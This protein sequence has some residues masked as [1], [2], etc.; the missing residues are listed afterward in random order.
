ME[1]PGKSTYIALKHKLK[2]SNITRL[3][4]G[5]F[6]ETV[7]RLRNLLEPHKIASVMQI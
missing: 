4:Q 5:L 7:Y 1:F 3:I 6:G 2:V